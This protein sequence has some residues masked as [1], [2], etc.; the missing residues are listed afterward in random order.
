MG[1]ARVY[2]FRRPLSPTGTVF[3]RADLAGV[4]QLAGALPP[5]AR[6]PGTK[7]HSPMTMPGATHPPCLTVAEE[8]LAL[9]SASKAWNVAGP[10]ERELVAAS[11]G[12]CG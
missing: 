6:R 11:E 9:V 5:R 8:G 10:E 3:T 1:G 7:V 12:V 4:A 2:L